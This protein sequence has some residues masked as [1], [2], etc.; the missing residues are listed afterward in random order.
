MHAVFLTSDHT[1][2]FEA[3]SYW[4]PE[5]TD[6]SRRNKGRSDHA[7]HIQVAEPL[8]V[9]AVSL[10]TFQWLD[11]FRVGER[12]IKTMFF[13]NVENRDSVF[14]GRFHAN[15][16]TVISSK[17]EAQLTQSFCKGRKAGLLIFST[18]IGIRNTDAGI[19]PCFVDIKTAT[20]FT[21]DFKSQKNNLLKLIVIS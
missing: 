3:V 1:G 19:E 18:A 9:F 13:Q 6:I 4:V 11:V 16:S 14:T 21:N 12:D 5:L 2:E 7:A 15:V 17:P 20:V 8:S 10:I